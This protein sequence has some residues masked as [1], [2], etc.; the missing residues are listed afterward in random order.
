MMTNNA[1]QVNSAARSGPTPA[2]PVGPLIW[3]SPISTIATTS[4]LTLRAC[5]SWRLPVAGLWTGKLWCPFP[6]GLRWTS[7]EHGGPRFFLRVLLGFRW[8]SSCSLQPE[9][10]VSRLFHEISRVGQPIG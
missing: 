3:V 4:R 7:D 2:S 8:R 9:A 6:L 10:R 5:S 1:P